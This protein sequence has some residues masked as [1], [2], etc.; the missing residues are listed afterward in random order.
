[1]GG[2]DR[3]VVP[4]CDTE[5]LLRKTSSPHKHTRPPP[6]KGKTKQKNTSVVQFG[7]FLPD[8]DLWLRLLLEA[9]LKCQER[10]WANK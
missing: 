4:I 5:P 1:M 7:H 10:S 2:E 9:L 8:C 3:K 6:K